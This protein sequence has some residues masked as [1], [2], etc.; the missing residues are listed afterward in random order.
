MLIMS[1]ASVWGMVEIIS[2]IIVIN[3]TEGRKNIINNGNLN[4]RKFLAIKFAN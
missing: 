2:S 1:E 3:S 4:M